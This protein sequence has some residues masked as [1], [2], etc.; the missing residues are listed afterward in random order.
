MSKQ[1]L[2]KLMLDKRNKL[3][4]TWTTNNSKKIYKRLAATKEYKTANT[5]MFYITK[6]NEV[7]TSAM[8][9][10]AL[11]NNKKVCAPCVDKASRTMYPT[12]IDNLEKDLKIGSYCILEPCNRKNKPKKID[13]VIT[14]GIAFD[15]RGYRLGWGKAYYDNFLKGKS[16]SKIGLVF[17]FQIVK[18]IPIDSHDIPMDKVITEKR[19]INRAKSDI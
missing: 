3:S 15:K 14:P 10:H 9:E 7:N 17:D 18:K 6:D 16:I 4:K 19:T 2:R 13:L 12:F 5:I 1:K 11:S 8:I